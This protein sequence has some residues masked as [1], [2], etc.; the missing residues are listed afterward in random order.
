MNINALYS[1]KVLVPLTVLTPYV[2]LGHYGVS[3]LELV[4][5]AYLIVILLPTMIEKNFGLPVFLIVFFSIYTLG[6]FGALINGMAW[7]VPIGIW[8][9]N[10]FYK[11][12]V[13]VAAFCIGLRYRGDIG[14]IFGSRIFLITIVAVGLIALI[15]PF[16]PFDSRVRYFGIF[17]NQSG[18]FEQY[19]TSRRLP[20][21]GLNANVYAF[22]VFSYLI[23]S[24]RAFLE[25]TV[26]FIVP[27]AAF[28][29]I[30]V[31][32]SK[33]V[34]SLSV[35]SC[36]FIVLHSAIRLSMSADRTG[37][38]VRFGKWGSAVGVALSIVL[39]GVVFF[40]TQTETGKEVVDSYATVQRFE[41]A[42]SRQAA[43]ENPQGFALRVKYW[44]KGIERAELAP[45][46][47]IAKD[48]YRRL[49]GTL[50]GF[51]NPHNE[52]LRMWLLYGLLGLCAWV[53]LIWHMSYKNLEVHSDFEWKLYYGALALF[54]F[55]DGGLDDPRVTVYF[56][57][58]IGLNWAHIR[59]RQ[60]E[61][62]DDR[63]STAV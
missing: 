9:L 45:V 38:H 12:I 48:P 55:F 33:L 21:L 17:Y 57:L 51:Y 29:V 18:D 62:R 49:S 16:L 2:F 7:N 40:A 39:I 35:A 30:L 50:A 32:S 8:N 24:F 47:G 27:L 23:F 4:V 22:V 3:V 1:P 6:Y 34:I 60:S 11:V 42:L 5:W 61:L 26:T 56:F 37:L 63:L 54:M 15:Y 14:E 41:A 36:V 19:L 58:M 53:Y 44:K 20:G 31:L 25:R 43:D 59:I 46:L 10:F 28:L 13:G 52:F